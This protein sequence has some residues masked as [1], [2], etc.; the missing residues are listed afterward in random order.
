MPWEI[1]FLEWIDR[2]F[3]GSE[4]IN[5]LIK[6]FSVLNDIG[7]LCIVVGLI[8]VFNKKYRKFGILMLITLLIGWILNDLILKNVI[9]RPRPFEKSEQLSDFVYS[10]FVKDEKLGILN[11]IIGNKV[12]SPGKSM[13]SGHT[14]ISF[15]AAVFLFLVNRKKFGIPALIIAVCMGLSRLFLCVHYPTDVLVGAI[16]GSTNAY[17]MY[18]FFH[19][20]CNN[21]QGESQCA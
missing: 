5:Y 6:Y 3:H 20:Y 18:R 10:M 17:L 13:P 16:L 8:L 7:L 14:Y 19:K 11:N 21:K 9:G 2:V 15:N 12:P 1:D 4:F